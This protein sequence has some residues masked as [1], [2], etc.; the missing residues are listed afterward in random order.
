MKSIILV[1]VAFLSNALAYHDPDLNYHLSQ[2]QNVQGCGDSGYSYPAPAVQLSLSNVQ[3]TAAP[4]IQSAISSNTYKTSGAF[5]QNVLFQAA[6]KVTYQAPATT[7]LQQP[8]ATYLLQPSATYLPQQSLT[9]QAPQT[10]DEQQGYATT[11]GL[12]SASSIRT[13]IPQSHYAQAPI[14]AKVTAAPLQAKFTLAPSRTTYV[15][16]NLVSQQSL[17]SSGSSA[18]A[19]LNSYTSSGGPVVSQ[20]YAAPSAGYATSSE[21]KDQLQGRYSV[22]AYS[23]VSYNQASVAAPVASQY[24][25]SSISHVSAPVVSQYSAPVVTN[26]AAP[27]VSH[28]SAP[29]VAQYAAPAASSARFVQYSAPAVAQKAVSIATQ[30]ATPT[31][32]HYSAPVAQYSQQSAHGVRYSAPVLQSAVSHV[33]APAVAIAPVARVS[34]GAHIVKN[35]HTEFLENYDPHPRYAFEYGVNDP[36]TGDIKQQ[37][38]E[39]DGE[40]VKGQYSLVEPDGSVRTVDYIADW[41][42]GFHANVHNSKDNQH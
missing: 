16:R 30:Y 36:H 13:V 23:S 28:Y 38:E 22:P 19:S 40:V 3:A 6:P 20:V 12:S 11:A 24:T 18:R 21:L 17:Y 33:A 9:N 25:T 2:V 1:A 10:F 15:S 41:E 37:K 29:A 8:S 31:V 27:T 5:A 35:A 42:T 26:Y 4:L 39:R 14:I 32:T 7:Y 34:S